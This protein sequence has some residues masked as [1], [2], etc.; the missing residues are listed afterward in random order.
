M[1][2]EIVLSALKQVWL[3]LEKLGLPRALMGGVALSAWER[4]RATQDVDV[5][6]DL[7]GMEPDR[8][9]AELEKAGLK[10]LKPQPLVQIG[11]TRFM[12]FKCEP[13]GTFVEVQVDLQFADSEFQ[14]SALARRVS[15]GLP[16]LGV[17]IDVLSCEDL[18]I[19]K[20]EAG[21]IID[22]ADAVALL[23]VNRPQIDIS[24]VVRWVNKAGLHKEW[25]EVWQ[26]AF[27]GEPP[28]S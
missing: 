13:K 22:R 18:I 19:M 6:V 23:K 27:P 2:G 10:R 21:R 25:T 9:L 15:G 8:F 4:V 16:D 17:P 28:P 3:A 7:Q 5:L 20:L 11:Q 26:E 14:K 1:P 24:Y 12:Q